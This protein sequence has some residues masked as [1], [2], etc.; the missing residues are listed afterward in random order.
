MNCFNIRELQGILKRKFF[1]DLVNSHDHRLLLDNSML[2]L[3]YKTNMNFN[4]NGDVLNFYNFGTSNNNLNKSQLF[5]NDINNA[6]TFSNFNLKFSEYNIFIVNYF[7]NFNISFISYVNILVDYINFFFNSLF[8]YIP[9]FNSNFFFKAL[10]TNFN[11]YLSQLNEFNNFFKNNINYL[12]LQDHNKGVV[13]I[14]QDNALQS[15]LTKNDFI[16]TSSDTRFTRF[17]NS[18]INYDYKTGH[19]VGN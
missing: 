10:S 3:R 8:F 15:V 17:S 4:L 11:L 18:L 16:E 19:Y 14:S 13:Y 2:G 1:T 6:T 9:N 5:Y 7:Y 12:S